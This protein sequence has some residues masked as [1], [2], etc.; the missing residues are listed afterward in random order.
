MKKIILFLTAVLVLLFLAAAPFERT[1][2]EIDW[3]AVGP[4]SSTLTSGAI[5]LDSVVG[6]SV[7]GPAGGGLSS[8]YLDIFT[9]YLA[10]I[11]LPLVLN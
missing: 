7:T 4:S 3:W 6:Q 9:E 5:T 11:Y 1:A 10:L 2:T 8:G